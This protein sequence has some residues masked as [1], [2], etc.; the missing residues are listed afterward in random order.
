MAY[1]TVRESLFLEEWSVLAPCT[2][3]MVAISKYSTGTKIFCTGVGSTGEPSVLMN[4]FRQGGSNRATL[5]RVFKI[6]LVSSM[7]ECCLMD[8]LRTFKGG[9]ERQDPTWR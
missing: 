2:K 5:R 6:P 4:R 9:R 3:S 7:T 1:S 8:D